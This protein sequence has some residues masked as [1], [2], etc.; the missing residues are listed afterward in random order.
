[1]RK[2]IVIY[3]LLSGAIAIFS[4]WFIATLCDKGLVGLDHTELVGYASFVIASSMIFFG[5]KSYRDNY[6]NGSIKFWKGVQIG[7]LITLIASL[8]YFAGGELYT[9]A[10]P[11]FQESF[12]QK[13]ID[14]QTTKM[15][16][17]GIPQE[18]I[19]KANKAT[20]DMMYIAKNNVLV[21]FALAMVEFLPVGI[22][23]T[24]ISA[25]ILRKQ[26]ILPTAPNAAIS[27]S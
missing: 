19:Y 1:M 7:V 5:I 26:H 22:I 2:V 4:V 14:Y 18:E 10:N 12:T 16:E 15:K 6:G 25:S 20:I 27:V 13:Y 9:I 11:N 17:K 23:I 3:G 24:L 21:R 8:M